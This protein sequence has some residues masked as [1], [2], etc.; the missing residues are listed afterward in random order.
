MDVAI[1]GEA[2]AVDRALPD[3]VI[4]ATLAHEAATGGAQQFPSR[5]A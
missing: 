4:A 5:A 1:D 3:L 2:L